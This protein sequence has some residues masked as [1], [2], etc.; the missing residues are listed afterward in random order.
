[1]EP[2]DLTIEILKGIREARTVRCAT[3]STTTSD[4][5]PPSSGALPR[6]RNVVVAAMSR[7]STPVA[8]T[9]ESCSENGSSEWYE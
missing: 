9:S 2:T 7:Q 3:G 6:S 8:E 1:M 5:C 4:G